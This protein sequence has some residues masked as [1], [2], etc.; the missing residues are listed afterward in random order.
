[1]TDGMTMP[2]LVVVYRWRLIPGHEEA[3]ASAWR[4]VTLAM[5]AH[6]SLGSRLHR[7]E[8]GLWYGYAQWPDEAT[9]ERAFSAPS[10]D[11]ALQTRMRVCIEE[12]L[13]DIRLTPVADLLKLPS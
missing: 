9:R 2:G 6:G 5:L 11:P 13:P 4:E 10:T 8:D 3:F 12:R 1:M 7:G